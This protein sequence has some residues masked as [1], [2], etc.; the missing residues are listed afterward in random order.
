MR[1]HVRVRVYVW[2]VGG[3]VGGGGGYHLVLSLS[4]PLLILP[5]P[6]SPHPVRCPHACRL[7]PDILLHLSLITFGKPNNFDNNE[8]AS[9]FESIGPLFSTLDDPNVQ[10]VSALSNPQNPLCCD[11]VVSCSWLQFGLP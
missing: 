1:V 5:P 4:V 7:A 6:R 11:G 2:C 10:N 9:T 3:W 8:T